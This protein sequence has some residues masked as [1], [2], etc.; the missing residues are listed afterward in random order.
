MTIQLLL[1]GLGGALGAVLRFVVGGWAQ[2]ASTNGFPWGTITVNLIGCF[3]IGVLFQL[4]ETM[5]LG[6]NGR[7][8]IFTGLLGAFT[9][10]S[11]YGLDLVKLMQAGE[12][13]QAMLKFSLS[14]VG[15]LLL[16]M[17]GIWLARTWLMR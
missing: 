10:F 12:W 9:T 14:N 1:I 8:F 11:T 17:I 3:L 2:S 15:G 4:F 16:V 13:S 7:L 6:E 5:P